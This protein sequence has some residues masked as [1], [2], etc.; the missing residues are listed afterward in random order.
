MP[1][2]AS[3]NDSSRMKGNSHWWAYPSQPG[4]CWDSRRA[5]PYDV[6][7]QLDPD[8]PVG[9]RGDRYDRYCIRIEEMRQSVRIIVQCPN[10]MPSGMIKAD[11][12]HRHSYPRLRLSSISEP[13][14][15]RSK[16]SRGWRISLSVEKH[17]EPQFLSSEPFLFPNRLPVGKLD[18]K[19]TRGSV[20][21]GASGFQCTAS[22]I[23]TSLPADHCRPILELGCWIRDPR[24]RLDQHPTERGQSLEATGWETKRTLG[25]FLS[26]SRPRS[27]SSTKRGISILDHKPLTPSSL[28]LRALGKGSSDGR[29]LGVKAK[30]GL[31]NRSVR[32]RTGPIHLLIVEAVRAKRS[33][34]ATEKANGQREG[35]RLSRT[36]AKLD[37]HSEALRVSEAL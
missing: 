3:E 5:A 10:Q 20:R 2:G 27:R 37:S 25:L 19:R 31:M 21:G 9:T 6:H 29:P 17:W 4:V 8:V 16:A 33:A 7:D 1:L 18:I 35:S 26:S 24:S 36:L 28:G 11:D 23:R 13:C 22:K 12:R 34:F 14:G 15:V 30:N 32:P